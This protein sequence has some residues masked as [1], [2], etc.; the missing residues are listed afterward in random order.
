MFERDGIAEV[1]LDRCVGGDKMRLLRPHARVVANKNI[2]RTR[3]HPDTVIA[4]SADD[5]R[6][7]VERDREPK[8]VVGRG[9]V[10]PQL[11]LV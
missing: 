5:E 10:G 4:A 2:G 11:Y 1:V 8:T 6:V 3:V 9:V 7:A